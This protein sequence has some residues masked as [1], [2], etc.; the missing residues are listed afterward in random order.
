MDQTGEGFPSP[1]F[2]LSCP[3]LV[4]NKITYILTDIQEE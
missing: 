4:M 3:V 1:V 2:F